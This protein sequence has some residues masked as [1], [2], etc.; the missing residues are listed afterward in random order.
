MAVGQD[1]ETIREVF[2]YL[3][4]MALKKYGVEL[5][6]GIQ[7]GNHHHL[8]I[9]DVHG[10]RPLFKVYFHALVGRVINS[11]RGRTGDFWDSRGS[12][13]TERDNDEDSL[14]D[15]I[16]N[17]INAVSAGLVKWPE[18]W[19]GFTTAGWAFGETRAFPRPNLPFFD[20]V[21]TDWPE[22]A[23]ITRTRPPCLRSLSDTEA[24]ALLEERVRLKCIEVQEEMRRKNRRFKQL[25]K[26]GREKWWKAPTSPEDRF[27]VTPK[28]ASSCKWRRLALLQRNAEWE[29]LYA[30]ADAAFARGDR[31]ARYPHGTWLMRVRYGVAIAPT[32]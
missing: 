1:A 12:C 30:A 6:A 31:G 26:L 27:R 22:S 29:E 23:Y 21:E 5:H 17:D 19:P 3:L 7:M 10:L 18:Q 13:D 32:T 2:G 14:G 15:L 9:T 28:V 25:S 24:T 11:V 20:T 8:D 16:Y 4:A